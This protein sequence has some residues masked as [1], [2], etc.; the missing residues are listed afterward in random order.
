[1]GILLVGH[2]GP[3]KFSFPGLG[4]VVGFFRTGGA[5]IVADLHI[6]HGSGLAA[7]EIILHLIA[8]DG[9][10]R[11]AGRS[12]GQKACQESQHCDFLYVQH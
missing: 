7:F 2:H 6:P 8:A 4:V 3:G 9:G 11:P 10:R 5:V 12:N 1:M